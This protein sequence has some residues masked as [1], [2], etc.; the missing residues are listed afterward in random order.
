VLQPRIRDWYPVDPA[1]VAPVILLTDRQL[2][3]LETPERWNLVLATA[4]GP[5]TQ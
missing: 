3:Q 4:R 5:A 2:A 1:Q